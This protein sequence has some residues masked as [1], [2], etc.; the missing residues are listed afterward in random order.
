MDAEGGWVHLQRVPGLV[1]LSF[2]AFDSRQHFLYAVHGDGSD[3]SSFAIG[4]A[5]R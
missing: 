3:V 5:G 2:L 1:N 4:A